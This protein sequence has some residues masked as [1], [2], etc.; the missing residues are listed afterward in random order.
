MKK[1]KQIIKIIILILLAIGMYIAL[2]FAY[3][4]YKYSSQNNKIKSYIELLQGVNKNTVA[5]D[6]YCT[7][8]H[9]KYS[10][11]V[12]GCSISYAVSSSSA[13]LFQN[14][15]EEAEGFGWKYKWDNTVDNNKYS[16]ENYIKSEVYEFDGLYCS[17][18]VKNAGTVYQYELGCSGP[19]KAEWFPV[20][21]N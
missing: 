17:F 18:V 3:D 4:W 5:S 21:E 1:N 2:M 20:R 12:L 11:G 19:A 7:Y 15:R 9:Q 16:S 14:S 6:N 8:S 13:L 10:K